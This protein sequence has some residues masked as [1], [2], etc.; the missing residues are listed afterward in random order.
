MG[1]V[2]NLNKQGKIRCH[3]FGYKFFQRYQNLPG[4]LTGKQK[5][6]M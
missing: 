3:I 4:F 1:D 6:A 5:W 2:K